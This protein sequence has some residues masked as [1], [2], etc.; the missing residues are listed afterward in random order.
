MIIP[1][2]CFTCG[3]VIGNK[4]EAFTNLLQQDKSEGVALDELGLTRYC[5]RRMLLTHVDIIEKL[6]NYNLPPHLSI[7][8]SGSSSERHFLD[9]LSPPPPPHCAF[10]SPHF[11]CLPCESSQP[12]LRTAVLKSWR[13][14][15]AL[16]LWGLRME[17]NLVPEGEEED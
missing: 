15:P 13:R 6:L 9:S 4:W 5:C 1:V 12:F 8:H 11:S 10:L 17:S 2:R 16:G 3:K 7:L 14:A